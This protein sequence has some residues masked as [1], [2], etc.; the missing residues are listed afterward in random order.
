[1][2]A[3]A[4]RRSSWEPGVA[5][6]RRNGAAVATSVSAEYRRRRPQINATRDGTPIP[7]ID[8]Q[9]KPPE[10]G[11]RIRASGPRLVSPGGAGVELDDGRWR[12]TRVVGRADSARASARGN[13]RESVSLAPSAVA[14]RLS[15]RMPRLF[16]SR[17]APRISSMSQKRVLSVHPTS[18]SGCNGSEL[19]GGSIRRMRI[20]W[21]IFTTK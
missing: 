13:Q 4:E 12:F 5:R 17:R 16:A 14:K 20:R 15:G 21:F 10:R 18:R 6:P 3:G 11:G 2:G 9:K 19:V 1:M 8:P 7:P